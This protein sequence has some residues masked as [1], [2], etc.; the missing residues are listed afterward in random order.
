MRVFM[1]V[2]RAIFAALCGFAFFLWMI[3]VTAVVVPVVV[4][5]TVVLGAVFIVACA[6]FLWW[7]FTG[8]PGALRGFIMFSLMG[9]APFA[10]FA[11]VRHIVI[12]IMRA[13]A[14]KDAPFSIEPRTSGNLLTA[15]RDR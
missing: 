13:R 12:E 5:G 1:A 11:L 10:A 6:A 2:L 3:F 15:E 7:A 8:N 4:V 9:G 14:P